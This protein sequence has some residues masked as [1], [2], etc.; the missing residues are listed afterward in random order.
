MNEGYTE[1]QKTD[2]RQGFL[3]PK[4]ECGPMAQAG[5]IRCFLVQ[6]ETLF[7]TPFFLSFNYH[8]IYYAE[9]RFFFDEK[10]QQT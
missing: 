4:V 2:P 8:T 1:F 6:V 3:I 10:G 5:R 9:I 7:F